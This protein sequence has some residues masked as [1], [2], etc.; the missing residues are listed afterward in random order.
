MLCSEGKSR[1][2]KHWGIFQIGMIYC[3]HFL[4]KYRPILWCSFHQNLLEPPRCWPFLY[5]AK[6]SHIS[7]FSFTPETVN[8]DWATRKPRQTSISIGLALQEKMYRSRHTCNIDW[9]LFC[10][11]PASLW[12]PFEW[13][14]LCV[15][16]P[17][18]LK[19]PQ[20]QHQEKWIL[21]EI[22]CSEQSVLPWKNSD[23]PTCLCTGEAALK[24]ILSNQYVPELHSPSLK[25]S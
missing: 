22:T 15:H 4:P 9:H 12:G 7:G 25:V 3:S 21:V 13:G 20:H 24:Q 18:L 11:K 5:G 16:G 14:G 19:E 8:T 2:L 17:K 10:I 23:Y 1:L 6:R